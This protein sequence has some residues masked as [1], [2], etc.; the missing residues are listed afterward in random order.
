NSGDDDNVSVLDYAESDFEVEIKRR[1]SVSN[2]PLPRPASLNEFD[3][4]LFSKEFDLSGLFEEKMDEVRFMTSALIGK[5]IS[6]LEEIA[7]LV[8]FSMRKKD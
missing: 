8:I 2:A 1:H 6:K 7:H 3:I 5:I 4:I